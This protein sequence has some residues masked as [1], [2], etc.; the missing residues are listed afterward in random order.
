[1]C[2][3]GSKDPMGVNVNLIAYF[4]EMTNNHPLSVRNILL[5]ESV[6][7]TVVQKYQLINSD[8]VLYLA[9]YFARSG[10]LCS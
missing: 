6:P 9:R 7:N 2:R 10:I 1:M 4:S 5:I 8:Q 3:P